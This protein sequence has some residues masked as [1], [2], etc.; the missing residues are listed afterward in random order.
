[1]KIIYMSPNPFGGWATFTAHLVKGMGSTAD[2]ELCKVRRTTEKRNRKFGYGLEYRNYS[3]EDMK[4]YDGP[5]LITAVGKSELNNAIELIKGGAFVVIHDPN[6]FYLLD[7]I[8]DYSKVFT[9]R[10]TVKDLIPGSRLIKHPYARTHEPGT[11]SKAELRA[12]SV[13]R[14]DF[15]KNTDMI[16]G[17]SQLLRKMGHRGVQINGFEN[18]LYGKFKLAKAF[19]SWMKVQSSHQFKREFSSAVDLCHR[20][21]YAVDLSVIQQDGGGTQYTFLEAMDAG[22]INI[23]HRDWECQ[24]GVMESGVNCLSVSSEEELADLVPKDLP[25]RKEII[26]ATDKLLEQH[27]ASSVAEEV[28]EY[29]EEVV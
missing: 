6:E 12:C 29:I 17:A 26:Q 9:I 15:D 14:I 21:Y 4:S 18:R 2:V 13:A 11:L 20:A 3:L 27:E 23:I 16:I 1:M 7:Y 25:N 24:P 19:P 8:K 5:L 10:Q 28:K 22:A